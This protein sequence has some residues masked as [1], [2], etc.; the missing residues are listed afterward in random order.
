MTI[1]FISP[2]GFTTGWT[3]LN[4]ARMK[5]FLMFYGYKVVNLP[6]CIE[7]SHYIQQR[8]GYLKSIDCN[9]GEFGYTWH[10]MYFSAL[11]FQHRS[12]Q[13][14]IRQTVYDMYCGKDIFG[15]VLTF[16]AKT[17]P[18]TSANRIRAESRRIH[19]YCSLARQWIH[20]RI[21]QI[22]WS[23]VDVVG[24]SCLQSQFLTNLYIAREIRKKE[25][26]RPRFIFGGAMFRPDNADALLDNFP[27]IQHV[28]V[29]E[30]EIPLLEMLNLLKHG[31]QVPR[32]ITNL[33]APFSS[34]TV[35][36]SFGHLDKYPPPD[37]DEL[38][39]SKISKPS[40]T[41]YMGKGCSHWRC[42][43]CGNDEK[44]QH[45]R[46]AETIFEE[47]KHLVKTYNT[48]DINFSDLEIN[49]SPKTL[50]TLCD[51]LITNRIK[52]EA[53]GEVNARH[54]SIKLFQKMK[55]AGIA[56]VQVGIESFSD[57]I[58]Q[59]MG[60][61]ATV[62][63]NIKVLKYAA[64][65]KMSNILFNLLCNHPL[66]SDQDIEDTYQVIRLISHL[67][68]PPANLIFNEIELYRT[69]D[70]FSKAEKFKISGIKDYEYYQRC[71]P[72][73]ALKTKIAMFNLSFE[74]TAL[75]PAWRKIYRFIKKLR[76]QPVRLQARKFKTFTKIYDS[77]NFTRQMHIL[78]GL[79]EL[80]LH[81]TMYSVTTPDVIA[82]ALGIPEDQIVKAL[83]RL[84][85]K[86]LVFERKNHF[87]GL[88]LKG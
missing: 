81:Q 76:K 63:D 51:L 70:L 16:N 25:G 57:R 32:V 68:Q 62:M 41:T 42:S 18:P 13:D 4:I 39:A 48:V 6:L 66:A 2:P 11:L 67:L 8:Y 61:P 82:E 71:Y 87:L 75:N 79:N 31:K 3:P 50:E 5:A 30:G 49:G 80:V 17:N 35:K 73:S 37:F 78:S 56:H 44:G 14:L 45:I 24:F 54:T 59:C 64:E 29:G 84:V 46:P 12:S 22:D 47:I 15:T 58:L 1:H 55:K 21:D 36:D 72:E 20:H 34:L 28:I 9:I 10:E 7:F 33:A 40:L 86:K 88:P 52:L 23:K 74:R 85:K 19:R 83:S 77:R 53:W 27:E 26:S 60:K 38:K 43:F 69:S 65:A